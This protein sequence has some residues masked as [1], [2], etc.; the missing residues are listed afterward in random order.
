MRLL[1][2]IVGDAL[3]EAWQVADEIRVD[4]EPACG[5]LAEA[6]LRGDAGGVIQLDVVVARDQSQRAEETRGVARGEQLL[7]DG[8]LAASACFLR[9]PGVEIDPVGGGLHVAAAAT[10]G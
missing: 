8:A 7:W 9:R 4:A 1:H 6:D 3:V 10:S 2:Q 5:V